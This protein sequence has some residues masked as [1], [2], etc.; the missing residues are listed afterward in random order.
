MTRPTQ[1][2][3][4]NESAI[5]EDRTVIENLLGLTPSST[6]T[7][8]CV[9]HF[10]KDVSVETFIQKLG[11]DSHKI[12]QENDLYASVMIA[13][14]IL[15]SGAGTSEL[16]KAPNYNLFGIKGRRNG[17]TVLMSTQ[18]LLS[19]GKLY[20]TQASFRVYDSYE[21]SLKDYTS[22]LKEG[23][24]GNSLFYEGVWKSRTKTYK[25]ATAFLTGKYATD[26]QYNQKLNGLIDLYDVTRYDE[27]VATPETKGR[28]YLLP[29]KNYSIS[30][31]F[32][33][34]NGEFHRGIDFA[35]A[36]REPIYASNTGT[37]IH[38][39]YH[40][41]WGNYVAIEHEDGTT[42][43]YAH[44]DEYT[45]S[46]REKVEQGQLIGYVGSTRRSTGPH[47]HFEVCSSSSLVQEHLID[48]LE[49]LEC[50]Y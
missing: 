8:D 19:D 6:L 50:N 26:T 23:P 7:V 30:C 32:G 44:Q 46:P 20:T 38:A 12:G 2:E 36:Q 33:N 4:N 13:Q 42:T 15:E 41:S 47:L 18:E 39:E 48:P 3:D 35:T 25:E 21:E 16:A 28:S 10:E 17:K 27:V 9:P 1:Q 45:V 31:P 14:P 29:V 34:R 43:L 49:V 5:V 37:V 22:L 40:P 11:E 24:S